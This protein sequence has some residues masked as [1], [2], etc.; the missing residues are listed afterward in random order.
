MDSVQEYAI[1]L[2]NLKELTD[3]VDTVADTQL[4]QLHGFKEDDLETVYNTV[5]DYYFGSNHSELNHSINKDVLIVNGDSTLVFFYGLPILHTATIEG[6]TAL[7]IWLLKLTDRER[8]QVLLNNYLLKEDLFCYR[9]NFIFFNEFHDYLKK[10]GIAYNIYDKSTENNS[11]NG[12]RQILRDLENYSSRV[13]TV[14]LACVKLHDLLKGVTK[15]SVVVDGDTLQFDSNCSSVDRIMYTL[16]FS[17][18][19]TDIRE[20]F[21]KCIDNNTKLE[22]DTPSKETKVKETA[23]IVVLSDTETQNLI[24]NCDYKDI[25]KVMEVLQKLEKGGRFDGVVNKKDFEYQ[26]Y[27]TCVK[28]KTTP[29]ERQAPFIGKLF[30]ILSGNGSVAED[31]YKQ[32]NKANTVDDFSAVKA[33]VQFAL[34]NKNSITNIWTNAKIDSAR[35]FAIAETVI[36]SERMS[37]KQKYYIDAI[38]ETV[39]AYKNTT[40]TQA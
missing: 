10:F 26:V 8:K 31:H 29:T 24:T 16:I 21:Q 2:Q 4:Q 7:S 33:D 12:Y 28:K 17:I 37:S 32:L 15:N 30:D 23:P 25:D 27:S 11:V 6:A 40:V 34:D 22:F 3:K 13:D 38:V 39:K 1:A 18:L 36:K 5:V 19:D 20:K 14:A 35:A 9:D